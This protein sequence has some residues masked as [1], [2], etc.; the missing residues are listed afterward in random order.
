ML[1]LAVT[2]TLLL[3]GPFTVPQWTTTSLNRGH[4]R[5]QIRGALVPLL[6]TGVPP[7]LYWLGRVIAAFLLSYMFTLLS[8]ALDA[9]MIQLYF[10]IP[11]VLNPSIWAAILVSAPIASLVLPAAMFLLSWAS[12]TTS[13]VTAFLPTIVLFGGWI[14]FLVPSRMPLNPLA[15][16]HVSA[17]VGIGLTVAMA[18][19]AN[20]IKRDRIVG[21][22]G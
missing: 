21:L 5:D 22:Y 10:K 4:T 19:I 20:K 7:G 16:I 18:W 17:V 11:L 1:A 12:R 2:L 13:N 6:C 8:V 3:I 14:F 9:L 15:A